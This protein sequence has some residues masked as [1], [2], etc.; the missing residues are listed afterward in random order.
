MGLAR[1]PEGPA[2]A[3]GRPGLLVASDEAFLAERGD[4][5]RAAIVTLIIGR[6][7]TW[8]LYC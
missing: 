1:A 8:N 3:H 7:T 6:V 2:P 4:E 5:D